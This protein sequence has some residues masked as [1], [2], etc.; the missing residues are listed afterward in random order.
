MQMFN[1]PIVGS[2][3]GPVLVDSEYKEERSKNSL[4]LRLFGLKR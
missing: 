3:H 4:S 2:D 1:L